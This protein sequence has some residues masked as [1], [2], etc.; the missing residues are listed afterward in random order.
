MPLCSKCGENV[1]QN[2]TICT[3]CGSIMGSRFER[4]DT[5]DRSSSKNKKKNEGPSFEDELLNSMTPFQFLSFLFLIFCIWRFG[6]DIFWFL[7][8]D[9]P[10]LVG[11]I[12]AVVCYGLIR[13]YFMVR[14]WFNDS[15]NE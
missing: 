3:H 10:I 14:E 15:K 13:C 6:K 2:R 11:I 1:E 12:F 8:G 4:I 9:R 5:S 7:A